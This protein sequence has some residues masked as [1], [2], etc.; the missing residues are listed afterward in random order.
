MRL[1]D[2][3]GSFL[4]RGVVSLESM[5]NSVLLDSFSEQWRVR[6]DK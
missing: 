2:K 5:V 1:V 4:G 6:G 3:L